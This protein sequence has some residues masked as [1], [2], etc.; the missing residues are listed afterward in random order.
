MLER[1]LFALG[2]LKL[3]KIKLQ[4]FYQNPAHKIASVLDLPLDFCAKKNIEILVLDF[5]GV[6]ASHGEI[7]PQARV[8]VWLENLVKAHT[9]RKICILSNKPSLSRAEFFKDHFPEFVW[10]SGVRKKPYPDGLLKIIQDERVD[11][12][13]V[14]LIDDRLLTGI[15][16]AEL[17]G[18]QAILI[19]KPL[20]CFKKHF[21]KECFFAS[22]RFLEKFYLR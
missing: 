12:K 18:T 2:Q 19:T 11:P 8:H 6:L 1:I 9:V 5:D 14:C 10:V 22:L 17:A 21:F 16:A 3:K 13:L 15:L 4:S 7:K 20:C